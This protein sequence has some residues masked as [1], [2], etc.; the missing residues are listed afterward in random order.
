MYACVHRITA[1]TGL[2]DVAESFAPMFELTAPGTVVFDISGLGRLYGSPRQIAESI[3][4]RAG[5]GANVAVAANVET[6]IL[7]ARNF[8][9]VTVVRG[10]DAEVLA[11]LGI[12][13]LP[14]SP[15]MWETLDSWGIRSLADF[16]NLPPLGIAERLGPEGLNLQDLARGAMERPL[17]IHKAVVPYEDRIELE[18]P[19]ELLEPLLFLIARILNDLCARL[20]SQALAA[21]EITTRLDLENKTEHSRSIRL[22]LPTRDSRAILK[23]L[24]LDLEAHPPAAPMM[25]VSLTLQAVQPRRIQND[26]FLPPTP[27]PDKLEL[28][29]TRIRALVGD[30]NVGIP[31]LLDTHRPRP[32]RLSSQG[33][34]EAGKIAE[35]PA[36]ENRMAVR[37][38]RPPVAASVRCNGARPVRV[39]ASDIHG[40]IVTAAGPWRTCG[41]WWTTTPWARDEWD[42]A[43]SNEKYYRIYCEPPLKWFVE[44]LYD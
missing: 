2:A 34:G 16:A 29:L 3:A 15:E 43:L 33:V 24:Q 40:S 13:A 12:E 10:N 6:A 27:E 18:H 23:L 14:L 39:D 31:E 25:A 26:I 9:G 30:E 38:F 20:E 37:Y 17:R 21:S 36:R 42:V 19:V 28:T 11:P 44:A 5:A 7:A 32:F 8:S 22:P 35:P 41:E 4:K 1:A